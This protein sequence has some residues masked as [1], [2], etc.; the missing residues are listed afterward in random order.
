MNKIVPNEDTGI[1]LRRGVHLPG[2]HLFLLGSALETSSSTNILGS[3]NH[4]KLPQAVSGLAA[5]VSDWKS[6]G[7]EQEDKTISEIPGLDRQLLLP[8]ALPV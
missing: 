5:L 7:A 4:A 8:A 3:H 2:V 6:A 1:V